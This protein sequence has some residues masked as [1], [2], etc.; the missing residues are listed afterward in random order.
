MRVHIKLCSTSFLCHVQDYRFTC[1]EGKKLSSHPEHS[2]QQAFV[3]REPED[4]SVDDLPAIVTLIQII[5]ATIFLHIV[6]EE[7][8]EKIF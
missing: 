1:G 5:T 8:E 3:R 2:T 6:P 7:K 4:I